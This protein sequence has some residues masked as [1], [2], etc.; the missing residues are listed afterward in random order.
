M[1]LKPAS[2]R[3]VGGGVGGLP[4]SSSI[5]GAVLSR[6]WRAC[7]QV[8]KKTCYTMSIIRCGMRFCGR[9]VPTR[10]DLES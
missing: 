1:V 6:E 10:Q 7:S 3:G 5:G 8:R 9:Q 2:P 4:A